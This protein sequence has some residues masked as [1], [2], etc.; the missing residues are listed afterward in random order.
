[1]LGSLG[2]L[3]SI[4]DEVDLKHSLAS[5]E[6]HFRARDFESAIGQFDDEVLLYWRVSNGCPFLGLKHLI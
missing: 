4:T 3:F 2:Y 1:M 6:G 5:A